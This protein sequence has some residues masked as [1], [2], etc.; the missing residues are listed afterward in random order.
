MG[1]T[2]RGCGHPSEAL[3]HRDFS[4]GATS[5]QHRSTDEAAK[6]VAPALIGGRHAV[7][8]Q[9][10]HSSTVVGENP[11]RNVVSLGSPVGRT[12]HR[13]RL[14]HHGSE[15][16]GVEDRV[17]A[18]DDGEHPLESGSGVDVLPR[19][20]GEGAVG[21][22]D[23]LHEHEVPDL[24]ETVLTTEGRTSVGTI[25]RSLVDVDL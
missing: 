10:G 19:E 4:T 6:D 15:E 24:D 25:G 16:I 17:H 5:R 9:H 11:Q 21:L 7:A 23:V 20:I 2:H 8:D 22:C 13:L 1:V 14:S 3:G 18:L 12:R